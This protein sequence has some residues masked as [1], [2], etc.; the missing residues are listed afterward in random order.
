[1]H[2]GVAPEHVTPQP[3]QSDAR[4][5]SVSQPLPGLLSQSPSPAAHPSMP[6][7]RP[8]TQRAAEASALATMVQSMLQL[9]QWCTSVCRSTHAPPHIMLVAHAS[10]SATGTSRAPG[11]SCA[12][13]GWLIGIASVAASGVEDEPHAASRSVAARTSRFR[14]TAAG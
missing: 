11:E 12:T 1:V 5:R 6:T 7:Q 13:S 14:A 4:E 2:T 10:A 9:P 8:A 3:P